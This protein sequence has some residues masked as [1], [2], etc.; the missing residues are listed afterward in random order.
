MSTEDLRR[1]YS[2]ARAVMEG[3]TPEQYA[4]ST[5]CASWKVRDL[6]NHLCEG[7]NWVGLCVDAGKAPDPDPTHGVNY[8]AGDL[9]ASYDI[10]VKATLA[11]FDAAGDKPVELPFGTLPATV[12]MGIATTDQFTHAWDLATATGQDA[13]LDREL[14][15]R[16]FEGAK[17]VI[18]DAFRGPEGSG[19]PFGPEQ[20][21]PVGSS[22]AAQLAAF[23]GR[24]V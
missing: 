13:N 23:L 21:A 14:A 11:A 19:A 6:V 9:L 2:I 20:H 17:L 22:A 1:A 10:G 15:G 24:A 4:L 18:A 7:A 3:V 12:F 16:L 5:P 8:A